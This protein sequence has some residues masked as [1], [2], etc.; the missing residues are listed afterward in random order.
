[1]TETPS[2]EKRRKTASETQSS[3]GIGWLS[4]FNRFID[5][6]LAAAL[7]RE[8][9]TLT[10]SDVRGLATL[11][12]G[13]LRDKYR[14]FQDC[15]VV[16]LN[17]DVLSDITHVYEIWPREFY[18]QLESHCREARARNE[19][20]EI[21]VAPDEWREITRLRDVV[22]RVHSD[23]ELMTV[24]WDKKEASFKGPI[25]EA[26]RAVLPQACVVIDDD[27]AAQVAE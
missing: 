14:E 3:S 1:M 12:T 23:F 26:V 11:Y 20:F 6:N 9:D 15:V 8:D 13:A 5:V 24:L 16:Y 4:V 19:N 27:D 7:E 2:A 17:P 10:L 25:Y 18:S 21:E 22:L